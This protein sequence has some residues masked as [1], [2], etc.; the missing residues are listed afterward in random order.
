MILLKDIQ[1]HSSH[2]ISH[3]INFSTQIYQHT[4]HPDLRVSR[5]WHTPASLNLPPHRRTT[6]PSSYDVK[7]ADI[8][9]EPSCRSLTRSLTRSLPFT[10]Y[11]PTS[12]THTI[13]RNE[14][15]KPSYPCNTHTTPTST[16]PLPMG[17]CPALHLASSFDFDFNRIP[18]GF[19]GPA[20][21][22]LSKAS[23]VR[24]VFY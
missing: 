16:S 3:I 6:L 11:P 13:N 20:F 5:R 7:F 10:P 14:S 2:L 8:N 9:L 17:H 21:P 19:P 18:G 23:L 4:C 1:L 12:T 22:R 24:V 15:K